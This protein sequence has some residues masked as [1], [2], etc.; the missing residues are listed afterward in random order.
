VPCRSAAVLTIDYELTRTGWAACTI[1]AGVHEC[2]VSAS[3]LSDALGKLILAATAPLVGAHRISIGFDEEPGE[4]RWSVVCTGAGNV[5]ISI[6]WFEDMWSNLPD[7]DGK[8]LMSVSCTPL[9][10]AKSVCN[11]ADAVLRKHGL[12]DYKNRWFE[13]D[14]PSREFDL[15]QSHIALRESKKR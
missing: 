13:Y 12:V 8:L 15:L 5:Q 7:A 9:E 6:L 14:F 1:R 3:Y 4:Y 10:F 11:A 2:K